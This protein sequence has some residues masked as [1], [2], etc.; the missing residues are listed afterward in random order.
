MMERLR[1][2]PAGLLL[3][4]ERLC[5][6]VPRSVFDRSSGVLYSYR[7]TSAGAILVALRAG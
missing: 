6:D 5:I 4:I 1:S 3:R 7:N 2:A